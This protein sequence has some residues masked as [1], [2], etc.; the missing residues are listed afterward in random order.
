M[1]RITP[2]LWAAYRATNYAIQYP[3]GELIV[4]IGLRNPELT[5]LMAEQAARSGAYL[6]AWN[7]YSQIVTT[8]ANA[9][10][11]TLLESILDQAGLRHLPCLGQDPTGQWTAEPGFWILDADR[12]WL[13]RLGRRFS[14]NA[15]VFAGPN[16]VPRLLNLR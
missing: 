16:G 5:A 14:Q 13:Q 6:T 10:A 15:L 3:E 2:D 11:N 1:T 7:P 12:R 8:E 9:A 4:R